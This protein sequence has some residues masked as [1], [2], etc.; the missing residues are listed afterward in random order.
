MK[1]SNFTRL[2]GL[3]LVAG[4]FYSC[5]SSQANIDE[6]LANKN[7]EQALTEISSRL[8]E[9]EAQPGLYIQRAQINATLAR[10]T[11]PELRADFYT[12]T[13]ADFEAAN[14]YG[15]SDSQLEKIDSLRQQYWKFEHNEGLRVSDNE[16]IEERYH[17]AEI[18]FSNALILRED[19]VSTYKNIAIAQ[20]NQGKIDEAIQSFKSALNHQDEESPEIYEN[21]GFLYLE[22]GDAEQAAFY[23]ELADKNIEKDQNLAFGLI[24]AYIANGN[25]ERAIELLEALVDEQ[26]DNARLRNVYGTQLYEI[27][28]EIVE[29]L[30]QAYTEQDT[31][32]AEQ[33]LFEVEG[34]ADE[35]E[36]QLIEAFKRD[37]ANTAYLES[38][39][40]FYNNLSAQHLSLL[41]VAFEKDQDKIREK[42]STLIDFAID[43]YER[44]LQTAPENEVYTKKLETLKTLKERQISSASE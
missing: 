27:T 10:E 26:P 28:S 17:R 37:T 21:L 16:D 41:E 20:Y 13:S 44:L 3:L 22:K 42:A 9:D 34:M 39:A 33:I 8:E 29:D 2:T 4:F 6:L 43:Y 12:R 19:A 18:F 24:N 25:N 31:V 35:A 36:T 32:L 23:Y 30:K 11:D 38:L 40:V 5:G 7:Y 1:L 15:A 14:I